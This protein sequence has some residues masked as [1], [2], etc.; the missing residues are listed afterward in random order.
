M[1]QQVYDIMEFA[2]RMPEI[3]EFG[4]YLM[5]KVAVEK[6]RTVHVEAPVKSGKR[7]IVEYLS[8]AMASYSHA[9]VTALHRDA[10]APQRAELKTYGINVFT[11]Q[12]SSLEDISGWLRNPGKKVIHLDES[13][14]GS[15]DRQKLSDYWKVIKGGAGANVIFLYSATPQEFE[16]SLPGCSRDSLPLISK[17]VPP[18]TYCGVERFLDAGLVHESTKFFTRSGGGPYHVTEQGREIIAALRDHLKAN[19]EKKYG[20]NV[21]LVRVSYTDGDERAI[22]MIVRDIAKMEELSDVQI[23]VDKT[24][25]EMEAFGELPRNVSSSGVNWSRPDFDSTIPCLVLY[26]Q[27]CSR[28]TEFNFHDRLFATHEY[29]PKPVY[30]TVLQ[31]TM[32]V[33]H[34]SSA[35]GEFQPIRVYTR[36][37]VLEFAAGRI[38]LTELVEEHGVEFGPR[39]AVDRTKREDGSNVAS[40]FIPLSVPEH[41]RGDELVAAANASARAAT[42][43]IKEDMTLPKRL[44]CLQYN[45]KTPF[46][47]IGEGGRLMG[48]VRD[49]KK[50]YEY[51]A[52][53][54]EAWDL[55][56][57]E[58]RPRYTGCY[59]DGVLGL[60]LRWIEEPADGK[61]PSSTPVATSARAVHTMYEEPKKTSRGPKPLEILSGLGLTVVEGS[62]KNAKNICIWRCRAG[63][64][65]KDTG[66]VLIK[67]GKHPCDICHA[68]E[69]ASDLGLIPVLANLEGVA[70]TSNTNWRCLSCDRLT[71]ASIRTLIKNPMS[72][73][74]SC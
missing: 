38:G 35:Y 55:D 12:T 40:V 41:A 52:V 22:R 34:Y 59:Q 25:K 74:C 23:Y 49:V 43:A 50:V 37:A 66:S 3:V 17:Y 13:D 9:F 32:R 47:G 14:Y 53:K 68:T 6:F 19:P 72:V 58:G 56:N 11:T 62:A 63:H 33:A 45:T 15:G 64:Q 2:V 54:G 60:S 48:Y 70:K 42:A 57:P 16:W 71:R 1:S 20:R 51:S 73:A 69:T 65:F 36:R 24:R 44:R 27:R 31:A 46:A 28:S 18:G 61:K 8:T 30:A 29:R 4:N 39:I 7:K 10:D 5:R 21:I 26:D 67:K